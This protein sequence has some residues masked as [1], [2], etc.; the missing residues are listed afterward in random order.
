[1]SSGEDGK[2]VK[3]PMLALIEEMYPESIPEE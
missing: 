2:M 1:M 3:N